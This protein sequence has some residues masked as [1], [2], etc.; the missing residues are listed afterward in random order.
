MVLYTGHGAASSPQRDS[1]ALVREFGAESAAD[2]L[3]SVRDL[4]AELSAIDVDWSKHTLASAAQVVRAE[5]ARRHPE[6][7]DEALNAMFWRFT[8]EWR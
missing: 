5:F 8:Y 2:L 6:L 3:T 7:T 1:G 4:L